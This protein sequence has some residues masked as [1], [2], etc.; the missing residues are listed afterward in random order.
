MSPDDA[1]AMVAW[2]DSLQDLCPYDP[3]PLQG[4]PLGMFHCP[5]CGCMIL[6]GVQHPPCD[7]ADCWLGSQGGVD[8]GD[9]GPGRLDHIK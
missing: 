5:T 4:L 8:L 7:P 1:E 2:V 6:A 9:P 3:R